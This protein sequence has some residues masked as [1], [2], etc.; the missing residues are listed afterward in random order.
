MA[1]LCDVSDG[2]V[3]LALMVDGVVNVSVDVV[4]II[5]GV[6][7]SGVVVVVFVAW[8]QLVLIVL[9]LL[10][11]LMLVVGNGVDIVDGVSDTNSAYG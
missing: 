1:L 10:R 4:V 9:F 6:A 3:C 11:V 8:L 2:D 5:D 7:V